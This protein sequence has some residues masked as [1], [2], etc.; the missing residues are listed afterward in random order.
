MYK[1]NDND[2]IAASDVL[3]PV[4]VLFVDGCVYV[5]GL[6][7]STETKIHYNFSYLPVYYVVTI[8]YCLISNYIRTQL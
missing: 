2:V 7:T 5:E 4:N 1:N 3:A 8:F 6:I